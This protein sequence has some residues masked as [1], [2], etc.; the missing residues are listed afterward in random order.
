MPKAVLVTTTFSKSAE[1]LRF[2]LAL[3]TRDE[4]QKAGYPIIIVD[5]S[6]EESMRDLLRAHGATVYKEE[7]RGMGASR[8]QT[9]KAGID[10]G[11]DVIVWLEP[12]KHPLVPLL[13]DC[14]EWV[15]DGVDLVIPCRQSLESLPEY[16][17]LSE[18]RANRE[19]G[20][21][22]GRPDLDLMFGPRVMS[23]TSA[24]LLQ[25]YVGKPSEDNWQILFI[26]VL[27]ALEMKMP[28]CSMLV[29]YVHPPEQTVA[30]Q[31]DEVM[32]KK[33]DIQ[34]H[35]LVDGMRRAATEWHRQ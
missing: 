18:L 35:D 8:R 16:Q 30:E 23:R 27:Q 7:G 15:L 6:P 33:R 1:D 24:E 12:E 19:L 3:K 10:T 28:V 20:F 4:A 13:G 31:G 11:T 25:K 21:I 17:E 34:R 5:G 29:D 26:P 2:Q 14:I 9:I 32:N 22:T